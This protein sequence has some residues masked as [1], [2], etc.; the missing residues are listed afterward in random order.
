MLG[1]RAGIERRL[2][3]FEDDRGANDRIE[4]GII[5]AGRKPGAIDRHITTDN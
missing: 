3:F 1:N 4:D 2:T 5:D